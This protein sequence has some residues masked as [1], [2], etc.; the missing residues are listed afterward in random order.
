MGRL[1]FGNGT[2]YHGMFRDGQMNGFGRIDNSLK[3]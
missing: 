1:K 3:G 2:T